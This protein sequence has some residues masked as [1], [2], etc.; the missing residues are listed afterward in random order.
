[1]DIGVVERNPATNSDE[2]A[3]P[4]ERSEAELHREAAHHLE[5]IHQYLHDRHARRD[6]VL[7]TETPSGQQI[8]WIP[9]ESQSPDGRIAD[10]PDDD[11]PGAESDDENQAEPTRFELQEEGARLGPPG[12][13]PVVH[14]PIERIRPVGDLQDWL[15]KSG[16]ANR[17]TP[18]DD[19]RG[20]EPPALTGHKYATAFQ[21]VTC[22]GTEGDINTWKPYVEWSDEFSLCQ[23]WLVRGSGIQLQTV[24][25]GNTVYRNLNGDWE[26]HLFTY[27]TTNGYIQSGDY[28]GGYNQHVDGWVQYSGSIYPGALSRP[29]SQLGGPQYTTKL[30]VQL[31]GGNWWVRVNGI[32]MGYYPAGLF[33]STGLRFEASLVDWGGEVFDHP[34]HFGT[35]R[36]DMGSGRWPSEG[37]QY[38]AYVNHLQYQSS[39]TGALTRFA[40]VASVTHPACYDLIA[41]FGHTGSWGPHFWYGGPGRNPAC[42]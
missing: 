17:I 34:S 18:P 25:V 1:M 37:W 41:D 30:K 8:D 13:V 3:S 14:L 2:K 32:W 22:Y 38:A 9:I 20:A 7:R 35:S 27:Y 4:S 28:L 10:P 29:L 40:G 26:P 15:A 19:Q 31:T 39:P 23:L 11:R 16:R 6:V 12:T 5:E 33:S 24:E 21:S 42:P 36:T